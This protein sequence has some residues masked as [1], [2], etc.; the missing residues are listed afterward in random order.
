MNDVEV[1]STNW[2]TNMDQLMVLE[3]DGDV[4]QIRTVEMVNGLYLV[5]FAGDSVEA[6]T[7]LAVDYGCYEVE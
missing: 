7:D 3:R 1:L 2:R 6:V 5:Q 4:Y